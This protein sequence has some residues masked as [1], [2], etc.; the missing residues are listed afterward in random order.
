MALHTIYERVQLH[1]RPLEGCMARMHQAPHGSR[2]WGT[3]SDML[4]WAKVGV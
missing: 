4:E 3:P 2:E 1:T